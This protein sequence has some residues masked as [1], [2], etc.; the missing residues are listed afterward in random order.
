[1]LQPNALTTLEMAKRFLGI[2][3]LDGTKDDTIYFFINSAS[4]FIQEHCGRVFGLAVYEE[5]KAG[6]SSNKLILERYPINEL[7]ELIID[8]SIIDLKQIRVLKDKGILFR[9]S[10]GFPE[11]VLKGSFMHPRP[12]FISY[13]IYVR[14]TSGYVLPKDAVPGVT[15]RTLPYDL[16]MACLKMVKIMDKDK[17]SSEGKNLILKREQIGDWMGEYEPEHKVAGTK[18]TML[19]PDVIKVLDNY[20][21]KEFYI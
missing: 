9:P 5:T 7:E 8:T 11:A 13:N 20:K 4:D 2:D 1:M 16:E 21:L 3:A 15:D 6:R 19:D 14:Y 10:G 17:D 18:L 12:D